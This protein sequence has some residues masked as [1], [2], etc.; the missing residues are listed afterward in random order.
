MTDGGCLL[1]KKDLKSLITRAAAADMAAVSDLFD[2][3]S[4][5]VF[6]ICRALL[7][8]EAAA[9]DAMVE[10]FTHIKAG[11]APPDDLDPAI[12][13]TDLAR[14]VAGAQRKMDMRPPPPD[15]G[16]RTRLGLALAA[17]PD[18]Q[19]EAIRAAYFNGAG[20]AMIAANEG[21]PLSKVRGWVR[22]GLETLIGEDRDE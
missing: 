10:V 7:P 12:W 9:E 13:M 14:Q 11:G 8:E 4:A 18:G 17:L 22:Q 21:I 20:Y 16:A 2:A 15:L 19:G 1:V 3:Q 6:S 5:R